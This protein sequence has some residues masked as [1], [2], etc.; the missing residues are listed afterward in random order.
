MTGAADVAPVAQQ[1]VVVAAAII[2]R[3]G[4]RPRVL[5][6]QRTGPPALAGCWEW[7][8]GKVEPGESDADALRR[9]CREE[10]G[11]DIELT[12]RLGSDLSVA[13]GHW[14]LRLWA[15]VIVAGTP[16]CLEHAAL[17]WLGAD[18]LDDVRWLPSDLPLLVDVRAA[19][20]G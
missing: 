9:E 1:P 2:D 16:R 17:S 4:D 8:G 15:A 19:L 11:V 6:A 3:W 7:P 20:A 18:E 14:T 13:G 5:A 10:L 12:G